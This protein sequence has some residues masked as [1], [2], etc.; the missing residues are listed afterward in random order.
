LRKPEIKLYINESVSHAAAVVQYFDIEFI[1]LNLI[2][3]R[4]EAYRTLP[5]LLE[6]RHG[7]KTVP[8]ILVV[9]IYSS[10]IDT[11]AE[12]YLI[13]VHVNVTTIYATTQVME[14]NRC[15]DIHTLISDNNTQSM[16]TYSPIEYHSLC[17]NHTN[18]FCF[19]DDFYLCICDENH[20]RV[21]CF[22]YDSKLDQCSRC[23]AGGRCLQG[24]RYQAN[25]FICVCPSCYSGARCQFNSNSF[26]F[27][28][29]QLFFEDLV[30]AKWKITVCLLIIG[31]LLLS[32][33]ALPNNLFS[34][35]TFRRPKCLCNGVGQYLFYM[36]VI[37]QISLSVLVARL[38][39]LSA[40]MTGF[41]SRLT[42]D[43]IFCKMLNY[44]LICFTRI[45]YWLV[46]F[47]ATERVYTTVFLNGQ[48]LKKPYVARR[49]ITLV[50][51]IV[52]ASGAYELVFVKSFIFDDNNNSNMCIIEFPIGSRSK[53]MLIHQIVSIIHSMLPLFI[54]FCCTI[55]MIYVITKSKMNIR[56]SLLIILCHIFSHFRCWSRKSYIGCEYKHEHIRTTKR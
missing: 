44:L 38:I 7:Q 14:D 9:K 40:T 41:H 28:F 46:S 21:D 32:L 34:F 11:P 48:W 1:T 25:D 3:V 16:S 26:V 18:L 23:L 17:Q 33:I 55:T 13:S 22:L 56:T 45:S 5:K 2:L 6:Y 8:E 29:E 19:R 30:S 47:V 31:P 20:S 50:F 49:L 10:Q 43:H 36:S 53:W 24:D 27:I 39:H 12:I 37:N 52:F 54:N 42:I 51:F 35:I 4:Q 15:V